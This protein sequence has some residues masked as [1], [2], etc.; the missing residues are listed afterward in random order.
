MTGIL[1]LLASLFSFLLYG[2]VLFFGF[3]AVDGTEVFLSL[4]LLLTFVVCLS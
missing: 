3:A 1:S 2:F 4:M